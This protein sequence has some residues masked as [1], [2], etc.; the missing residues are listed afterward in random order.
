MDPST[1]ASH[2]KRK[3]EKSVTLVLEALTELGMVRQAE[4]GQYR[5]REG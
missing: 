2:Y 5:I 1:L 3:P 4:S